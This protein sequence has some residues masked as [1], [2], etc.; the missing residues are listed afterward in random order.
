MEKMLITKIRRTDETR[1]DLY[2]KGHKWP[3]LK[4]FDIGELLAVGITPEDLPIGVEKPCRFLAHYTLSDKI[5]EAGNPYKD[6]SHLEPIENGN[7][8]TAPAPMNDAMLAAILRELQTQTKLLQALAGIVAGPPEQNPD[9]A[10]IEQA[11]RQDAERPVL[12]T[13]DDKPYREPLPE[14][15]PKELSPLEEWFE[16]HSPDTPTS[17]RAVLDLLEQEGR[18]GYNKIR[19]LHDA[20]AAQ[21]GDTWRGWPPASDL[22]GWRHLANVAM[23]LPDA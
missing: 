22:E 23:K 15:E 21:F 11:E 2:G 13:D 6:V 14:R 5:N 19:T 16:E 10:Y 3:D 8:T 4:L 20:L 12:W 17:P 7:G 18:S 9:D 1:A